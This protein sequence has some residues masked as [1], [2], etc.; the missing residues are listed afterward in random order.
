MIVINKKIPISKFVSLY[1][2]FFSVYENLK[3]NIKYKH[4]YKLKLTNFT[5]I[6]IYIVYLLFPDLVEVD[7]GGV[8]FVP[9]VDLLV[10]GLV[11]GG[12][13]RQLH[14]HVLRSVLS[15]CSLNKD[16]SGIYYKGG[17]L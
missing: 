1:R 6:T 8:E 5:N 15:L 10:H 14:T 12:V 7:P 17:T 16:K 13:L 2:L 3:N 11:D 9:P 4:N